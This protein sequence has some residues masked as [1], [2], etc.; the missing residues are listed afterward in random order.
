M[1]N[2]NFKSIGGQCQRANDT[3][4]QSRKAFLNT[5][6]AAQNRRSCSL[7]LC[8]SFHAALAPLK[9]E[10]LRKTMAV[11]HFASV[12]EAFFNEEAFLYTRASGP[13]GASLIHPQ[14][15]GTHFRR[16]RAER[17]ESR[18]GSLNNM[19]NERRNNLSERACESPLK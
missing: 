16:S 13:E 11:L 18:N 4:M 19:Q 8:E 15:R 3:A 5:F 10:Q 7:A 6:R 12:K 1:S 9:G 14:F 2:D 17:R